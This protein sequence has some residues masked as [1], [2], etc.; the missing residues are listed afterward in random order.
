MNLLERIFRLKGLSALI[1]L[2]S[3]SEPGG[4]EPEFARVGEPS[5]SRK[6]DSGDIFHADSVRSHS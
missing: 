4:A 3:L 5:A 2:S 1:S 6:D